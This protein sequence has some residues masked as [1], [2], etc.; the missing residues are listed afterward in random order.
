MMQISAVYRKYAT[1]TCVIDEEDYSLSR[2]LALECGLF[3]QDDE[4]EQTD[5]TLLSCFN[6]RYRRWLTIGFECKVSRPL[7][8]R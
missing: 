1:N 5:P 4:D 2:Q 8:V 7:T 3:A 6:C